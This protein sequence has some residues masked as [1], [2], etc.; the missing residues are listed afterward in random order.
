MLHRYQGEHKWLG[1]YSLLLVNN[2]EGSQLTSGPLL[3]SFAGPLDLLAVLDD[4]A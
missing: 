1:R 3:L 4:Q 2:Y